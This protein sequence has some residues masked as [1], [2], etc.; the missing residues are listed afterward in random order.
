MLKKFME[1]FSTNIGISFIAK[2]GYYLSS[3]GSIEIWE[4]AHTY[5]VLIYGEQRCC[6][7]MELSKFLSG[8]LAYKT[9]E[10]YKNGQYSGTLYIS[11]SGCKDDMSLVS[12][13]I[14]DED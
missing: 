8:S 12:A 5:E 9:L 7:C 6:I 4:T 2:Q 3:D 11:V 10:D 13:K 1:D 14:L